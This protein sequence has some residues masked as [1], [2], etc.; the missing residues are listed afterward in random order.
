MAVQVR[1]DNDTTPFILHSGPGALVQDGTIAQDAA[2]A[3]ALAPFTVLGEKK[4]VATSI[5]A[6]GGNTGNGTFTA[7]ALAPGGPPLVGDWEVECTVVG[8]THGGTFKLTDPYGNIVNNALVMPDTAGGVLIVNGPGFVFTIT[9]GGT[10]FA[11]GD[12]AVI[13]IGTASGYLPLEPDAVNGLEKVAG[14][15]IGPSITAAAIVAGAI[16]DNQILTGDAFVNEDLVV[17]ENSLNM[18]SILPSGLSVR[19]ELKQLG[20]QPTDTI[21]F[22][23]QENT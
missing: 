23:A 11:V 2:R 20:I 1:T 7:L 15:Y 12:K 13:V 16:T 9:D 21:A 14:I 5:T 10:N 18:A 3:A 4:V 19:D 17:L 8:V 22:S 6:D